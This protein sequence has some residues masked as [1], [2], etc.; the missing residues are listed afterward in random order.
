[1][2]EKKVN[3]LGIQTDEGK[4]VCKVCKRE[5]NKEN[6]EKEQWHYCITI[7]KEPL[8]K[9]YFSFN[10]IEYVCHEHYRTLSSEESQKF[11]QLGYPYF[12]SLL[13]D[14]KNIVSF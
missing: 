12:S 7:D 5:V 13:V 4:Y 1:M 14:N 10:D 9:Q 11:V 2:K 6:A 3:G 8:D